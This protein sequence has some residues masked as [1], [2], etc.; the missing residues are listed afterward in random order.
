MHPL[1]V[2][3]GFNPRSRAGSDKGVDR[4]YPG[5][6]TV[7]IHA[8]ARGATEETMH[9]LQVVE[10]FNPRSRAGSDKGV[11]RGYPG[12]DTVSIH[13]PARGATFCRIL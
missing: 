7:S 9:P 10:G 2:V 1:Q 5:E 6:D 3:E 8:P 13:A 12:E 4:G 11:D